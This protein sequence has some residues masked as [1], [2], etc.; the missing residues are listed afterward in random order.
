MQGQTDSNQETSDVEMEEKSNNTRLNNPT[1]DN[2]LLAPWIRTHQS[3]S[4]RNARQDMEENIYHPTATSQ[5]Y[6]NQHGEIVVQNYAKGLEDP[7]E[8]VLIDQFRSPMGGGLYKK[9]LKSAE[10]PSNPNSQR[11][12]GIL[13]EINPPTAEVVSCLYASA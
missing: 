11:S 7:Y 6:E 13:L 8:N 3:I 1:P 4:V 9:M 12:K 2:P 10:D 5:P